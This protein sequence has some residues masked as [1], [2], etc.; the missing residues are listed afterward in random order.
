M[1]S[2][3]VRKFTVDSKSTALR[4]QA[5]KESDGNKLAI[6]Y[7][8]HGTPGSNPLLRHVIH[9]EISRVFLLKG[10]PALEIKI[11]HDHAFSTFTSYPKFGPRTF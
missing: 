9:T 11:G 2:W 6:L 8:I 4:H 1:T 5:S 10:V 3:S 7:R